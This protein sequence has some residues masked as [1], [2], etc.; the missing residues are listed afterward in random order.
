MMTHKTARGPV[1]LSNNY[2][3]TMYRAQKC[4]NSAVS[5]T[6]NAELRLT[7]PYK[8]IMCIR[9]ANS[10]EKKRLHSSSTR[11]SKGELFSKTP[12]AKM[13]GPRHRTVLTFS[14]HVY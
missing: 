7:I 12:I 9:P 10:L 5:P 2:Y 3:I 4:Q 14:Y 6:T 8:K 1:P 13:P 11:V